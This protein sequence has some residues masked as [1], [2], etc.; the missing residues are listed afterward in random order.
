MSKKGWFTISREIKDHW[1]WDCEFS[2]GQAWIDLIMHAS[3]S[4]DRKKVIKGQMVKWDRGQQIRSIVTLAETWG[5]TRKRVSNF[6]KMLEKDNMISVKKGHL[7]S[8][9][10]LCNYDSFQ[11][12]GTG[13][14]SAN[15]PAEGHQKG[16]RRTANDSQI[17]MLTMESNEKNE[18]QLNTL[19]A[20][21]DVN[22]SNDI[23]EIFDYWLQVMRK[24]SST[25]LIKKR[26]NAVKAR[27]REGYT[28]DQ[29]KKAILGCSLSPFNMGQ[30]SNGK[31]YNDLELICRDGVKLDGYA[32]NVDRPPAQQQPQRGNWSN[33]D[34]L[35]NQ[36]DN[37]LE[38]GDFN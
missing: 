5:W 3:H 9:I 25:K 31:P 33:T 19:P 12:G 37:I 29:I 20:K 26:E 16:I 22:P 18:K 36:F 14:D 23:R 2:N 35:A 10:T 17:T 1:V 7:T 28:V 6:L 13:D 38:N 11:S 4:N 21:A 27:L 32:E 30:N 15:D 24:D 8:V 34:A